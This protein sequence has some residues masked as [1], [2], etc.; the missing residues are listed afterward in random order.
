MKLMHPSAGE[1]DVKGLIL[2]IL[3]AEYP[4]KIIDL[5]NYI[6]KRYGKTVSF[7]AV[8]K[9]AI[10]LAGDGVLEKQ[11][12]LYS[13]SKGWV[14]E[15]KRF[16]DNLYLKLS[17]SDSKPKTGS[18]GEEISAFTFD[19]LM[20]MMRSW[21]DLSGHW[22]RSFRKGDYNINCYQAPH[23]WE[24]LTHPEAEARLMAQCKKKGIRAYILCT[25]NTPL[26]MSIA[27]F[28]KKIGV[29]MKISPS[30]SEFDKS[31]Y[32]GTYGD[33]VI[34]CKYPAEMVKSLDNFFKRNRAIEKMD[35]SEL[36]RIVNKKSKIKMTVI[37]N[38]D[39]AKHINTSI[40]SQMRK[41]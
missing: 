26:D 11:A 41:R 6:R 7:Q 3:A 36:Y 34:Q 22:Y 9:A 17:N 38:L 15:N 1:R 23:S 35:L 29:D 16:M 14:L 33:L 5:T 37:K 27:K 28:H 10:Q 40:I 2:T 24:A 4:L 30:N 31:Y 19:S 32:V 8:R 13:I 18:I 20:E 25:E 21:E 39:M 12:H